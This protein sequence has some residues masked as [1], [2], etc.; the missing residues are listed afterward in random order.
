[1]KL[2]EILKP[3]NINVALAAQTKLAAI[4]EL[5]ALLAANGELLDQGKVLDA[6]LQRE[7]KCTT[8]IGKGVA[9]PHGK[10]TGVDRLVVTLGR[11]PSPIDFQAIDGQ[12]VTLIWLL[13][14]PP[15]KTGPHIAALSKISQ[16]MINATFRD[17]LA[18]AGTAAEAYEL[19][20]QQLPTP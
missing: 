6:V 12:P 16:L 8:G 18:A 17:A 7:A 4:T 14:S 20:K 15:D 3:A 13:A 19:I 5:V 2:S 1:M 11:A 10:C 9:V